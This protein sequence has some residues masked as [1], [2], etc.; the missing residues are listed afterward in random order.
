M[1]RLPLAI[2]TA[3]HVSIWAGKVARA[4]QGPGLVPASLGYF[5]LPARWLHSPLVLI[6][7]DLGRDERCTRDSHAP[8]A[9]RGGAP[10]RRKGDQGTPRGFP[11]NP[12][13]PR[14][15]LKPDFPVQRIP[16]DFDQQAQVAS[17][18][19]SPQIPPGHPLSAR[20]RTHTR[21]RRAAAN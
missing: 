8:H 2:N 11:A 12:T 21:T 1:A 4:F 13:G 5:N 17:A 15:L 3:A 7:A 16:G 20:K 10:R 9:S 6:G 19:P 14:G 18:L